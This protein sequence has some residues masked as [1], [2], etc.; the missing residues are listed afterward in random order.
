MKNAKQYEK[1]IKAFLHKAATS[2]EK[3]TQ[4]R[5]PLEVLVEA[6]FTANA[7]AK[8]A[9]R[10]IEAIR[11]EFV[12]LNEVRVAPLRDI[13][14][15]V[16]KDYPQI[17]RRAQML[18]SALGAIYS[19]KSQMSAQYM[20]AMPKKQLR[21]HLE[22]IGLDP[23]AAAAVVLLAFGGHAIPVDDTLVETLK[24]NDMVHPDADLPDVQGFLERVISLKDAP[25]AHEAFRAYVDKSA[26]A[27]AKWRKA[28]EQA[29]AKAA[30]EAE[31]ERLEK[32]KA[33]AASKAKK[34]AAKTKHKTV[35]KTKTTKRTTGR[36]KKTATPKKGTSRSKK[37]KTTKKRRTTS[38]KTSR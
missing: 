13:V 26:K 25:A 21:K 1:K 4:R 15:V 29:A 5:D 20:A 35:K 33:A 32:E 38:K 6:V 8:Q 28:R 3:N 17:Q 24:M 23:Y 27:L 36:K 2:R 19:R 11:D 37:V 12:D 7:S 34:K 18:T 31:E 30:A 10:A 22:Q 9:Q 16:G 14:A